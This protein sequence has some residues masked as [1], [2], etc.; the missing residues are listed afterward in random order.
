LRTIAYVFHPV[1]WALREGL[2]R[3]W[4]SFAASSRFNRSFFGYRDPYDFRDTFCFDSERAIPNCK[5]TPPYSL[6]GGQAPGSNLVGGDAA[7][8]EGSQVSMIRQVYFPDVAF[9]FDRD[10]LTALGKGRVRQIAQLLAADPAL[11]VTVEG[12]TDSKGGDSY[13]EKLGSRRSQRVVNELVE[14]GI[15]PARLVQ[16]SKGEKEMLFTEDED[17]AHA[18]NRRVKIV[19]DAGTA[20]PAGAES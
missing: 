14:L 7:G 16:A 17:W 5:Q 20:A 1:G 9:M 11:R 18:V 8:G 13:N 2:Y 6:I 12:H 15:D 3:P 19:V 10:S 4:S